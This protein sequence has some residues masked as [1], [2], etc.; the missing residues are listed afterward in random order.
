MQ[1]A[2][3]DSWLNASEVAEILDVS[4]ERVRILAENQLLPCSRRDH[5]FIYPPDQVQLLAQAYEARS[6]TTPAQPAHDHAWRLQP[7]PQ[8]RPRFHRF[9]VYR[10][11]LCP[12]TWV[13]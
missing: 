1:T 8:P 9:H 5:R 10:C 4:P 7:D 6:A 13:T 11:D 3:T 12:A 2:S